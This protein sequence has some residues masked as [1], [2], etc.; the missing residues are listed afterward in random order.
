MRSIFSILLDVL[1]D[2]DKKEETAL[3]ERSE[4]PL[5]DI[6]EQTT[7]II[8]PGPK[9]TDIT[10]IFKT[11]KK[12]KNVIRGFQAK[13]TPVPGSVV[14]CDLV[15]VVEHSGIYIGDNTIVHLSGNGRIE[16]V[17]PREFIARLN[18]L[19]RSM[20]I[21]VSCK[22]GCAVGS[23]EV[24]NRAIMM[25]GDTRDYNLLLDNCHQFTSGC[26]SGDFENADN[27]LMFLKLE[28]SKVLG[29]DCWRA[30]ER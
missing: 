9:I 15:D 2:S 5:I 26:L 24:A 8:Y 29:V 1:D 3:I 23:E 18:G 7:D 22:D 12:I 16:A 14:Y 21:E 30:W 27:F 25:I 19:N 10:K 28:A 17:S 4:S 6:I 13:V 11:P 20:F